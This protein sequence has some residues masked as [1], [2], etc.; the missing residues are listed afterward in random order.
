MTARFRALAMYQT[1]L[2]NRPEWPSKSSSRRNT[3]SRPFGWRQQFREARVPPLP[4]PQLESVS[5]IESIKVGYV[6]QVVCR[7][8]DSTSKENPERQQSHRCRK[9]EWSESSL[10]K[11]PKLADDLE[12]QLSEI[13]RIVVEFY[14]EWKQQ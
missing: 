6:K 3:G 7:M 9:R 12:R 5:C 4:L 1:E 10:V 13:A 11:G 2:K 14:R 8:N